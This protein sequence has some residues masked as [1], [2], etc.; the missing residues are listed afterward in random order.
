M[1]K[2]NYIYIITNTLDGKIYI[3]KHST[4][5]LSDG[6]LGSGIHIKR[7]IKKYGKEN[8][9]KE[10]LAYTDTKDSLNWLEKYYIRKYKAQNPKIGYNLTAGGDGGCIPKTEDGRKRLSEKRK[11]KHHTEEAKMK[12]RK[13]KTKYKW[14][15]Q[16]SEIIEMTTLNV[17]RWHPDWI[18]IK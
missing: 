12:M 13:P 10:I 5:D 8:F 14:L 4:N 18:K 7:A 6:Y 15:T 11:G 9:T 1:K 17:K 16:T 3:G 2:Y